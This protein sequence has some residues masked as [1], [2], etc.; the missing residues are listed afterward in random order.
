MSVVLLVC[1]K[2]ALWAYKKAVKSVASMDLLLVDLSAATMELLTVGPK[3]DR[4]VVMSAPTSAE[5][6]VASLAAQMAVL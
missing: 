6:L 5:C 4:M 1:P 3:A 2:A